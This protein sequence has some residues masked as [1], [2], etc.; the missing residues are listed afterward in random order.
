MMLQL[1]IHSHSHNKIPKRSIKNCL[2]FE[3]Q[4]V[5][6]THLPLASEEFP[7]KSPRD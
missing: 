2:L 1:I 7:W 4:R 3:F 5:Q 6:V